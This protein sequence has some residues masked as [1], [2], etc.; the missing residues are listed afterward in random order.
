[1]RSTFT[2]GMFM[3]KK[4]EVHTRYER[5]ETAVNITRRIG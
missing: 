2:N 4:C 5:S 1:M 3:I